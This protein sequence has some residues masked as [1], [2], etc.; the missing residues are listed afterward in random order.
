MRFACPACLVLFQ[1]NILPE[2]GLSSVK[3]NLR[4]ALRPPAPGWWPPAQD[5]P[6]GE[7]ERSDRLRCLTV[8][9]RRTRACE[10]L[11]ARPLSRVG[12]GYEK[13]S[14][15]AGNRIAD[16][17]LQ[18]LA[19]PAELVPPSPGRRTSESP[20]PGLGWCV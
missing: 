2:E 16:F 19:A 11:H 15:P 8:S 10:E 9:G 6:V 18:A 1:I 3:T 5:A 20:S 13:V 4:P 7:S 17:G 12:C 14:A